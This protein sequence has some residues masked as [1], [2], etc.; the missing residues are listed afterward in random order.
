MKINKSLKNIPLYKLSEGVRILCIS[1]Q[2]PDILIWFEKRHQEKLKNM[3]THFDMSV[4]TSVHLL[5]LKL[6]AVVTFQQETTWLFTH[7]ISLSKS[8]I[9]LAEAIRKTSELCLIDLLHITT[10]ASI[11][12]GTWSVMSYAYAY[13]DPRPQCLHTGDRVV[14]PHFKVSK[15]H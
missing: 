1:V 15:K 7:N 14:W 10:S 6:E 3:W 5:P 2:K 12:Q 11:F 8:G 9:K 4:G 13:G